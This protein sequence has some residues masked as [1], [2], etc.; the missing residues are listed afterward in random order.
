MEQLDCLIIG[1]NNRDQKLFS[2]KQ[3]NRNDCYDTITLNDFKMDPLTALS[4]VRSLNG[5]NINNDDSLYSFSEVTSLGPLYLANYLIQRRIVTKFINSFDCEIDSVIEI[6]QYENPQ[7]VVITTTFYVDPSPLIEITELI[8]KTNP[9]C[10]IIIGG[11]L[12]FNLCSKFEENR[13]YKIL[14]LLG[15]DIYIYERQ[16]ENTLYELIIS[17]KKQVS[18]KSVSNLFIKKSN[19]FVF[20]SRRVENN[21]IND[22]QINW[23][24]FNKKDL[25]CVAYTRTSRG[26][27]Y[28]CS[29]CNYCY[30]SPK[31]ELLSLENI[32]KDLTGL[33][34]LGINKLIFI[35]DTLNIPKKKF[36]AICNMMIKNNLTFEWYSYIRCGRLKSENT[37]KIMIESGCKGVCLGIES[38]SNEILKIMN[39]KETIED[40]YKGIELLNKYDIQSLASVIIGFPGETIRTINQTID[41]LNQA[42]PSFYRAHLWS[43]TH[44]SQIHKEAHKYNLQGELFRWWH[45]TMNWEDATE[46]IHRICTRVH[47][48][49]WLPSQ[50]FSIWSFPYLAGIGMTTNQRTKFTSLFSELTSYNYSSGINNNFGLKDKELKLKEFISFCKSLK[51]KKAKYKLSSLF[52]SPLDKSDVKEAVL[53][54]KWQ[55]LKLFLDKN[56]VTL[57]T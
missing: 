35:D 17:L 33:K 32:K 16:G 6:L 37:I 26:C 20:T 27:P 24:V 49:I 9:E 46:E 5:S 39:K 23:S 18:L 51:L 29:F 52:N 40:Y 4:Y 56:I 31:H 10:K 42:A 43:Y 3:L 57:K 54:K 38:G 25:S 53:D 2:A 15:G 11:P 34:N 28:K 45:N 8:K 14:N 50:N 21:K 36:E 47:N 30:F 41:F 48:S 7:I 13:L 22:N 19:S 1:A 55:L 44:N 12:I